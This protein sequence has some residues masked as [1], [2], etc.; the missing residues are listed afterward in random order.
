MST[1]CRQKFV[2]VSSRMLRLSC[3]IV[4]YNMQLAREKLQQKFL[5]VKK[6]RQTSVKRAC[7]EGWASYMQLLRNALELSRS[8]TLHRTLRRDEEGAG[9]SSGDDKDDGAVFGLISV[10]NTQHNVMRGWSEV[11]REIARGRPIKRSWEKMMKRRCLMKIQE[12]AE[13][14]REAKLIVLDTCVDVICAKHLSIWK[15]SCR[16]TVDM[17]VRSTILAATHV[18]ALCLQDDKSP[19]EDTEEEILR[20]LVEAT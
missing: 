3:A 13:R 17:F 10:C 20:L 16:E 2:D 18:F 12:Y 7:L 8:S 15:A 6:I 14:T 19:G 4:V 5:G 1:R 11:S 9:T